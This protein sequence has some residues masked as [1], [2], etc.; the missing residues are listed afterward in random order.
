MR[1]L[2]LT[3]AYGLKATCPRKVRRGWRLPDSGQ[4]VAEPQLDHAPA[5]PVQ[6]TDQCDQGSCPAFVQVS[7]QTRKGPLGFLRTL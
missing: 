6:P 7:I 5:M 1:D 3:A 4:P 2:E